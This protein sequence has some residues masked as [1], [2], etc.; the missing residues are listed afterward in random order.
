MSLLKPH[1]QLSW[2][3]FVYVHQQHHEINLNLPVQFN[4]GGSQPCLN[5]F[6]RLSAASPQAF[7]EFFNAWR[8]HEHKNSSDL[9]APLAHLPSALDI[10]VQDAALASSSNILDS[11]D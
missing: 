10:Y 2:H 9:V 4:L 6:F 5:L 7:F 3:M 11:P 1:N 8:L